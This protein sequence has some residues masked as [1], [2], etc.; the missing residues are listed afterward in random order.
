MDSTTT[1]PCWMPT[2]NMPGA[3]PRTSTFALNNETALYTLLL[4]NNGLN[5]V[6]D[7]A[8]LQHGLNTHHGLL[9]HAAV[10]DAFAFPYTEPLQAL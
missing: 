2:W 4:A 10:A 6:R 8:A 9:T 5:A 3:V 7:N 1:T